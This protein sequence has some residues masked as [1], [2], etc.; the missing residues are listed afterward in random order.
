MSIRKLA[1]LLVPGIVFTILYFN[2]AGAWAAIIF[3]YGLFEYENG[4]RMVE[5]IFYGGSK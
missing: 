1:E 4:A 3:P 2:D 5:D